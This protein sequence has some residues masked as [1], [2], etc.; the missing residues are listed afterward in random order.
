MGAA[1]PYTRVRVVEPA[2]TTCRAPPRPHLWLH[3]RRGWPGLILPAGADAVRKLEEARGEDEGAAADGRTESRA[4]DY[5]GR[6]VH[7][8]FDT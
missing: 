4:G 7:A 3:C 5:L 1:P 8:E 6:G 2:R